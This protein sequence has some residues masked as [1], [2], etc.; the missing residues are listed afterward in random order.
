[1]GGCGRG[2]ELGGGRRGVGGGGGGETGWE[3]EGGGGGRGDGV[4]R[5]GEE[6]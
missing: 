1:M 3:G 2:C 4:K 6:C 5:L